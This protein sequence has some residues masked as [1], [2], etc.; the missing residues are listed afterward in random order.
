MRI[1]ELTTVRTG[2][3]SSRKST[4]HSEKPKRIYRLL[5]LKCVS[6]EGHLNIDE[7]EPY[8]AT[9]NLKD[10]YLTHLGDVLVRLSAPYTAVLID[11]PDLYQ[12]LIPSHFAILRANQKKI[13]PEYLFWFLQREQTK[14]DLLKSGSGS[15]SFG[16]ISAGAISS[17]PIPLLP[18]ND[19]KQLANLWMLT[20]K[21]QELLHRLA[22]EK[23]KYNVL[24]LNKTYQTMKRGIEK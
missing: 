5:N 12:L 2:L 19:Q 20:Q 22:E 23:K 9:E 16:T 6:M 10:D 14:N 7:A 4:I 8:E 3:V 21:E 17:L 18:I 15:T 24:L 1:G 11:R 13:L